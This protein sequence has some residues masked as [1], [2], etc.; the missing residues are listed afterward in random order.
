MRL[1]I[2]MTFL[3]GPTPVPAAVPYTPIH[4]DPIMEPWR[5]ETYPEV[6]DAGINCAVEDEHGAIWFGARDGVL[7][8]DGMVWESYT[9]EDGLIGPSITEL[10]KAGDGV[11]YAGSEK[12]V[13][14]YANG[15]W[16]RYFPP[17][18]PNKWPVHEL[19]LARDGGLWVST[20]WGLVHVT[21]DRNTWITSQRTI[22]GFGARPS[23]ID[24]VSII[25]S[26]LPHNIPDNPPIDAAV[27]VRGVLFVTPGG[28]ADSSGI[29]VGDRVTF[30]SDQDVSPVRLSVSRGDKGP[31]TVE[32]A[33]GRTDGHPWDALIYSA[34]EDAEGTLWIG[35]LGGSILNYDPTN[36]TD[37]LRWSVYRRSGVLGDGYRPKLLPARDGRV[38]V[39]TNDRAPLRYYE[40]G[41]WRT[42]RD[43]A[44][45]ERRQ[46]PSIYETRDGTLWIGSATTEIVYSR[47]D[48]WTLLSDR[49]IPVLPRGGPTR[50]SFLE[51]DDG[52]LWIIKQG[53]APARVD[54]THRNW[55]SYEGLVYQC[56]SEDGARW[57]VTHRGKVVQMSREGEGGLLFGSEDGMIDYVT[58]VVCSREGD[59]LATG[60][61]G[62][63]AA[64]T[65][66]VP[67]AEGGPD[68]GVVHEYPELSWSFDHQPVFQSSDATIWLSSAMEPLKEKGQKGGMLRLWVSAEDIRSEH[69]PPPLVMPRPYG[70]GQSS[71]GVIWAGSWIVSLFDGKKWWKPDVPWMSGDFTECLHSSAKSGLWFGTRF[72]GV[73]NWDGTD[74]HHH[75]ASDGVPEGRVIHLAEDLDGSIWAVGDRENARYDGKTWSRDVFLVR[76]GK[77]KPAPDGS[78]WMNWGDTHAHILRRLRPGY[79]E[80]EAPARELIAIHYSPDRVSPETSISTAITEVSQPGNTIIEW[81]GTVPWRSSRARRFSYQ[82]Q[83]GVWTDTNPDWEIGPALEFSYRLDGVSW[84][85]FSAD[86]SV[87]LLALESGEHTIEVRARDRDFNVDSTPAALTFTVTSPVWAQTWFQITIGGFLC[88]ILIQGIRLFRRGHQLNRSNEG[89]RQEIDERKR[90]DTQ[91]QELRYLYT[92]RS[93]LANV[94]SPEAAMDVVGNAVMD[95]LSLTE[96]GGSIEIIFDEKS[97]TY[98]RPGA[99]GGSVYTR[100]LRWGDRDRGVLKLSTGLSLSEQQERTLLDETVAQIAHF[101]EARELEAQLLQ[102]ARLVSLGQVSAGIAHE[103]NQPLASILMTAGDVLGRVTDRLQLSEHDLKAMM[104]DILA[105]VRRM[106]QTVNHLRVFS[107]DTSEEVGE[108]FQV[109]DAVNDGLRMI[110]QQLRQHGIELVLDLERDLPDVHGHAHQLEQVIVNLL[111]NARDALDDSDVS[112][113]RITVRSRG[114]EGVVVLEVEDNGVGMGEEDRLRVFDPF[115]TTKPADRGTGLGL[116]ISYAIV[117]NHDG[118]ITC[119]SIVGSGTTFRVRIPIT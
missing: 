5:W 13:S 43:P 88:V 23:Y 24:S 33:R 31:V 65:R 3:V 83:D 73:Y 20:S 2:W 96:S 94:S 34:K 29:R 22:E 103:L 119:E 54:L 117:K 82:P 11:L 38:W 115:F 108:R 39:T 111:S 28:A 42:V 9:E 63:V 60:S 64:L 113:K 69:Y 101:I 77:P 27:D 25:P 32:V 67:E 48:V 71:D 72:K 26:Y 62:Q 114:E 90:I 80:P 35:H 10:V 81:E 12:G 57:F 6:E 7:R 86:R 51:T 56:E 1:V 118:E 97:R 99:N 106:S 61:H 50:C 93:E 15:E 95:V 89:L 30:L 91:L 102:S 46:H 21:D 76:S 36:Q 109:N 4:P 107:R 41:L 37:S 84:S 87:T 70:I 78:L 112:G 75:D 68:W 18:G 55:R 100:P 49:N 74:W 110:E 53:K 116:S 40:N 16:S 104:E 79:E 45:V 92:L 47:G 19:S 59:V 58:Q 98:G 85:A 14:R 8:Y 66:Y 105:L 44:L 17:D 52:Y